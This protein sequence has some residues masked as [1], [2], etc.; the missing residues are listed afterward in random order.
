MTFGLCR[1]VVSCGFLVWLLCLWLLL[2]LTQNAWV[3]RVLVCQLVE[4]CGRVL[5][6]ACGLRLFCWI[7]Y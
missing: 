7:G 6:G 3:L 2:I 5:P 4:Y 1:M